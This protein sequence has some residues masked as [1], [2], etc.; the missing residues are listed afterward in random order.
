MSSIYIVANLATI[1][2]FHLGIEPITSY[3]ESMPLFFKVRSF[4]LGLLLLIAAIAVSKKKLF[5]ILPII[6]YLLL[7]LIPK[8]V[9]QFKMQE[10]SQGYI[11]NYIQ[12]FIVFIILL[13]LNNLRR[14]KYFK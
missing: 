8:L 4:S 14:K 1:I 7:A 11:I 10:L 6:V 5:G 3:F 13:F 2:M 9:N 12:Y